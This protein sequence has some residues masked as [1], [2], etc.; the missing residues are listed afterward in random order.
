MR[1]P[2]ITLIISVYLLYLVFK[3]KGEDRN[4]KMLLGT[5]SI[6][7]LVVSIALFLAKYF[8]S[9]ETLIEDISIVPVFAG[10]LIIFILLIKRAWNLRHDPKYKKYTK[11]FFGFLILIVIYIIV[12]IILAQ[13]GIFG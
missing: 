9:Y 13:F 12:V 6:S 4:W 2:Y 3:H 11:L 8:P 1:N 5:I 10:I 7:G